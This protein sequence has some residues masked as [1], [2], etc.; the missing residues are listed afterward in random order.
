[1]LKMKK[2]L[3]DNT[4]F[5]S[6][7]RFLSSVVKRTAALY[8]TLKAMVTKPKDTLYKMETL[9]DLYLH[10]DTLRLQQLPFAIG[11]EILHKRNPQVGAKRHAFTSD[12]KNTKRSVGGK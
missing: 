11:D 9:L 6:Y 7:N 10:S 1:M 8:I 4:N 2:P 5:S 12:E 3:Y